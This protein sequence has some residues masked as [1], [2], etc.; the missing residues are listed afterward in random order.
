MVSKIRK[1]N[2]T[3]HRF[4][5]DKIRDSI[6]KACFNLAINEWHIEQTI[7]DVI[8]EIS[9]KDSQ[10]QELIY[11]TDIAETVFKRLGKLNKVAALRYRLLCQDVKR[12][13]HVGS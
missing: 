6:Y 11:T 2:S 8:S 5:P 3:T 10:V 13:K 9:L 4:N 7:S 12:M 1:R